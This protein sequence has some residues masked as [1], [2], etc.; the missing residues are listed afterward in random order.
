[1][2]ELIRLYRSIERTLLAFAEFNCDCGG[3]D[4]VD[5]GDH[6]EYCPYWQAFDRASPPQDSA[7]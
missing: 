4:K 3:K 2:N 6:M 5:P 1:M 7:P